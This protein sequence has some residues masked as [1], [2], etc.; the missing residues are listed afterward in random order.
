MLQYSGKYDPMRKL[1]GVA[2]HRAKGKIRQWETDM[3][4]KAAFSQ[5]FGRLMNKS[6]V[7]HFV[8]IF[9]SL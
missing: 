2:S 3:A 6:F 4:V 5:L 7:Q 9:R 1:Y 8:C